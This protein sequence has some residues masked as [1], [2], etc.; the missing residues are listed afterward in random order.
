VCHTFDISK[1]HWQNRLRAVQGLYL[2][3]FVHRKNQR[4]VRR[5]QVQPHYIAHLVHKKRIG[6]ELECVGPVRLESEHLE[7][8]VDRATRD[9]GM[10]R[11][12]ARSTA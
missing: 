4:T 6:G 1:P 9:P 7:D 8:T 3:L 11:M 5:V 10:L 12:R 2:A